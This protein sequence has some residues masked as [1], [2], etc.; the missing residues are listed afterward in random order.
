MVINV[1][2]ILLVKKKKKKKG[3]LAISNEIIEVSLAQ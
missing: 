3:K 1:N 2:A